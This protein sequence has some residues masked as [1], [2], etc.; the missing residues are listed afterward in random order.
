MNLTRPRHNRSEHTALWSPVGSN[1][2]REAS[3]IRY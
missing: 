2:H 3:H 1:L